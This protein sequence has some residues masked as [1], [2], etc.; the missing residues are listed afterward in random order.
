VLI[1]FDPAKR[2]K[3]LTERGLD[4]RRASEVFASVHL[5]RADERRD[6]GEPRFITAGWLDERIV[7]I[8]WTPRR[9]AR[10]VIS[11]RRANEREVE[12]LASHLA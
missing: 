11:M 8:V 7:L 4:F 3:T 5:T 12:T 6:Y 2:A 9:R 1:T 10:R